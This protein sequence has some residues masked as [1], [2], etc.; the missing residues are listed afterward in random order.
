MKRMKRFVLVPLLVLAAACGST[1]ISSDIQPGDAEA[2]INRLNNQVMVGALG[3][4]T[5]FV[6]SFYA[7]N[8]VVFAP[9]A[10]PL[11]GREAIRQL[12]TG[13]VNSGAFDLKLTPDS[14]TQSCDMATEVG[15]YDLTVT[16]KTAGPIVHDNGKYIV[17]WRKTNGKWQAVADMFNSNNPPPPA[18]AH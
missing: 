6:D 14:I 3:G 8:A 13:F 11:R 12:W 2:A 10:P 15:S 5:A 7:E 18:A 1:Q 4:S 16:P 9:N 17:A